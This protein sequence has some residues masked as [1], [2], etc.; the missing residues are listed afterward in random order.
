MSYLLETLGR[1]L[2][3]NLHDAFEDQLPHSADDDAETLARRHAHT[4]TSFDLTM[5]L[6]SAYLREQR[7]S[8]AR[9][10]FELAA[11]LDGPEHVA[12]LGLACVHSELGRPDR[13]LHY[14]RRAREGDSFDPTI[15]FAIGL[16]H[17]Q[18]DELGP[19]AQS[20]ARAIELCPQLRNAHERL[21]AIALQR[22]AGDE[23]CACYARLAELEPGDLDVL[24]AL[25]SLQLYARQ[26]ENA[27][28][29]FQRALLVEPE[30][31]D[32]ALESAADPA[33]EGQLRQAIGTL[34][35]LVGK[36]PGVS[37][38]RVHLADMYVKAGND[39]GAVA[40]YR[41][42]LDLHPDFLEATVKLGTQHLRRQ[43]YEEAAREFNRAVE[44]NDRLL[45]AFVGLG[46]AQ[47]TAGYPRD[48]EATFDLATSLAPNS[49]LLFS[50]T[51]R[52]HLKCE[53]QRYRQV[54]LH[55]DPLTT[56]GQNEL[57]LEAIRRHRQILLAHPRR[58][59]LH[60]RHGMLLRQIG[61]FGPAVD[62]FQEAV[63]INP[64]Y[65]KALIKLGI[66]CRELD[67]PEE[68]LDA[69]CRALA[70]E[71]SQVNLH[72][73]LGLL[74]AQPSRF[75][76]AVEQ[77]EASLTDEHGAA[78]FRY[79]LALALQN[80]GVMDRADATWRSLSELSFASEPAGGRDRFRAR[81]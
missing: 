25:A 79:N 33:D 29:T 36:Y 10:M 18:R 7:P 50:E 17:E 3:A 70:L 38:F 68:A 75:D 26:P 67:R 63:T 42:A 44:L 27:I 1:G 2:L 48:A 32:E 34:E 72:Y 23:A 51:N 62:A 71:E 31:A 49:T 76:V 65:V 66:T 16:C 22:G 73:Q 30:T 56:D 77:F 53:R 78:D 45:T 8:E 46:V 69:F 80:I 21:A 39:G 35:Q 6:G 52:L 64:S 58:A 5:R 74:F 20:Y 47:H 9:R 59:D 13:A 60:Y 14:L 55:E 11:R 81:R 61:S 40:Q 4:Q 43:R 57:V 54:L 15:Q 28:T 24:L 12:A 19:A 37:E 41:A